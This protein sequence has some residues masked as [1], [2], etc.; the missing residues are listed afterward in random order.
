MFQ[1]PALPNYLMH[2][3]KQ[4]SRVCLLHAFMSCSYMNFYLLVIVQFFFWWF[5][6]QWESL[7]F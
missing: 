5:I 7:S 3:M 2:A 1:M 6:L 4:T